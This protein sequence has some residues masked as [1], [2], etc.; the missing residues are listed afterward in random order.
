MGWRV[1]R[2]GAGDLSPWQSFTFDNAT[3]SQP[4]PGSVAGYFWS[5]PPSTV[6]YPAAGY[7]NLNGTIGQPGGDGDYRTSTA[8]EDG[9]SYDFTFVR[10]NLIQPVTH[11]RGYAFSVRCIRE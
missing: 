4:Y 2:S 10:D 7:R 3:A 9:G 11:S 6:W 1:P 8:S 5:A